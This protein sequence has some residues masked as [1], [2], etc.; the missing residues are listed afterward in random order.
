MASTVFKI[1]NGV[2][3]LS[4]VGA[5]D[6]AGWQTPA[7]KSI[8]TSTIADYT[9]CDM[10]TLQ[11]P[12]TGSDGH[13]AAD[14]IVHAVIRSDAGTTTDCRVPGACMMIA[15][16]GHGWSIFFPTWAPLAFAR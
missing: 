16:L 6:P 10:R 3:A 11:Y 7:G 14:V 5:S 4:L 9:Q 8:S 15:D 1:E 2:L 13:F 12:S